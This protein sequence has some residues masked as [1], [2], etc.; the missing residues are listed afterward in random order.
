MLVMSMWER[1]ITMMRSATFQHPAPA[2]YP[3]EAQEQHDAHLRSADSFDAIHFPTI[4]FRSRMAK[5]SH[6]DVSFAWLG[7]SQYVT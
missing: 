4:T 6:P 7:I 2:P 1:G 3:V 5:G